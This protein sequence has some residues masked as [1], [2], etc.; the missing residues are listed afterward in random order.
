MKT[1][2]TPE[3]LRQLFHYDIDTGIFTP[4]IYLRGRVKGATVG[5]VSDQGYRIISVEN[6][7]YRAHRL[8]WLYVHGEWPQY[9]DHINHCRDDNRIANLRSVS[10]GMNLHNRKGPTK[11]NTSGALGVIKARD[12][13]G[14]KFC[15]R[16]QF[17][18]KSIHLG[19]FS[20]LDD[21]IKA[22]EDKRRALGVAP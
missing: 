1:N 21:A 9:I 16:I 14:K 2:I 17:E 20:S 12:K 3:R 11:L 19:T 4:L 10:N 13:S 5:Y 22:R 18:G 8:A 7:E 15:A 6:R